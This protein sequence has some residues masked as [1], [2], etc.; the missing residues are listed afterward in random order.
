MFDKPTWEIYKKIGREVLTIA[1]KC[2][3]IKA[4][5]VKKGRLMQFYTIITIFCL[6][7]MVVGAATVV[8]NLALRDRAGKITYIRSFKRGKGVLI[9]LFALPLYWMGNRYAGMSVV[10]GLFD[11]IRRIVD[12][13]VLKYD[14]SPVRPLM[15]A[16]GFFAAT[17]Y[18]CFVLVAC[19]ALLF[20]ASLASQHVWNYFG[21]FRFRH[22]SKERL[23]LFGNNEHNHAIYVSDEKR[24][25]TIV[26]KVGKEEA[27]QL[28]MKGIHY[29]SV[30]S[31]EKFL[32]TTVE[33]ALRGSSVVAVVNTECDE[34]NMALC[35]SFI[36][37]L[38]TLGEEAQNVCF[39]RLKIF[40]FGDPRYEAIYEDI[41]ADSLGCI[42][43]INKY[44]KSAVD[45]IDRYPFT[46]FM[47]ERHLDYETSLVR[48][49]VEL[50]A[51]LIGFGKSNR[52]IFLTSVANNQFITKGENGV[53]LKKVKYHIFDKA[54]A[55]NNKNLNH[56]YHRYKNEF[57]DEEHEDYLPLPDYPAEEC[58]HRLDIND[59]HF[60]QE[61][62]RAVTTAELGVNFIV[63]AFG[64]DLENID[65]AQKLVFKFREWG[66]KDA[67][68]FVKTRNGEIGR[69]LLKEEGCYI[70][71]DEKEI[72]YNVE[73]I[74]GDGIFKMAQMR[75]EVYDLEYELTKEGGSVLSEE[76]VN[77]IKTQ[78]YRKWYKKKT[79]L[80]RESSLYGCLSL[81]SKLHMMGLDYCLQ[82]DEG[83]ALSEAEYLQTYAREDQPDFGY[84][85]VKADGKPIAHYTL[86]FHESRRKN[87]A[88]HEHLRWNSFMISKGM[89]PACKKL[90]MEERVDGTFTN[91]RNY[92]VRRHGNITTFAGLEEFRRMVAERDQK[93]GET[94]EEAEVRKDVIKYDYQLLDDAYW[95][96]T[97]NGYKIVKK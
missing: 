85:T 14:F 80:E 38:S 54:P 33:R 36:S 72:V 11:A 20:A 90:I 93:A 73:Q 71:C 3:K 17:V 83:Q 26:D 47:D 94:L 49:G 82:S 21:S 39:Q 32:V 41:V 68:I 78:A 89:I 5:S 22:S 23:V 62:R 79:Q 48:E 28:Y 7:L 66:L 59:K 51:V 96:L 34:K 24:Q 43:Y 30:P 65:M 42:S 97:K 2:D 45:F 81:R 74:L 77:E 63:I 91:G 58:F 50:N 27:L 16:N 4:I 46:K 95:L 76:K 6:A 31:F 55:E 86:Q 10:D 60:Y 18:V 52:Q 8:I 75:N 44:Q 29:T 87:L 1:G 35:R 70:I 57:E 12:L 69:R 64:S 25:K 67:V 92:A 15:N 19:N 9:Y 53:E 61:I 84:Y 88:V 13:V 37:H 40:V 56:N